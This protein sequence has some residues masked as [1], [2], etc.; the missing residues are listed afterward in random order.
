MRD[1]QTME[2]MWCFHCT[3][4]TAQ[5]Y[6]AVSSGCKLY[7]TKRHALLVIK[8]GSILLNIWNIRYCG[9]SSKS[10]IPPCNHCTMQ[11]VHKKRSYFVHLTYDE[12]FTRRDLPIGATPAC[13]WSFTRDKPE[14]FEF[15]IFELVLRKRRFTPA[16]DGEAAWGVAGTS[17]ICWEPI[18][19]NL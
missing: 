4:F 3:L 7:A 10:V 9:R 14:S 18:L 1:V 13:N 16:Q 5:N 11:K 15:S 8:H 6:P 12:L 17:L 2:E 19:A